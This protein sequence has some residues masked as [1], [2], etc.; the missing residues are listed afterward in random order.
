M[1]FITYQYFSF[2]MG[3]KMKTAIVIYA[4]Q[5]GNTE[6]IALALARGL[7]DQGIKVDFCRVDAVNLDKLP[8]YDLLLIGGPTQGRS[9]SKPMKEF[10]DLLKSVEVQD[11]MSFA[12]DTRV[13]HRFAGSAGKVIEK[14]LK[15]LKMRIIKS[16]ASAIVK[17]T[18]GPLEEGM[19]ELFQQITIEL[20]TFL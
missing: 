16:Y 11:K 10:L 20:A 3:E 8:E 14:Q 17:G 13:A 6:K 19:E 1:S 12:F 4:S 7:R 2:R 5:F 15:K 9:I 18:E